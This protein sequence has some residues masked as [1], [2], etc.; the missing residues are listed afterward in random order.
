MNNIGL[1]LKGEYNIINYDTGEVYYESSNI[2]TNTGVKALLDNFI[3]NKS[4]Y[5]ILSYILF[6]TGTSS[7]SLSD[8]ELNI[9]D[10]STKTF[11]SSPTVDGYTI[12][13][14][15]TLNSEQINNH[16]E[17]GVYT[18]NNYLVSRDTF[19]ALSIPYGSTVKIN[20][21]YSICVDHIQKEWEADDTSNIYKIRE[22]NA[23]K[24]VY[25]DYNNIIT[26]YVDKTSKDLVSANSGSYWYDS[27]NN[28]LY[29]N[30]Y[31]ELTS[32]VKIS[33]LN[34]TMRY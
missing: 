34:I 26:P 21:V 20:Y 5:G 6:G 29:V 23:V 24:E 12:I 3:N 1:S 16:T 28:M 31:T 9:A 15:S 14:T 4:T 19:T 27:T 30:P 8:T 22:V 2:I 18:T 17:L 10:S 11:I 33:D 7:P 25:E 32:T 13:F